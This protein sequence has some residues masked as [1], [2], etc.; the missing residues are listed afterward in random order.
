MAISG[1]DIP[2]TWRE[3]HT[4]VSDAIKINTGD[5]REDFDAGR[6]LDER[7]VVLP[8]AHRASAS[9]TRR[10][11]RFRS[12]YVSRPH[13]IFF[14]GVAAGPPDC[15]PCLWRGTKARVATFFADA[16]QASRLRRR[17][18]LALFLNHPPMFVA[19]EIAL[20]LSLA[21]FICALIA[22]IGDRAPGVS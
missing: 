1:G 18:M 16:N 8:A 4:P 11:S 17:P 3:R 7:G 15:R 21:L 6:G 19:G 2:G 22:A 9:S 13:T 5:S 12:C 10:V 20:A 14:C